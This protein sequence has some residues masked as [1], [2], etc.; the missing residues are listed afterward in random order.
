MLTTIKIL[1]GILSGRYALTGPYRIIIDICNKCGLGCIM[2]PFYSHLDPSDTR[3]Q[4]DKTWEEK[5]ISIDKFRSLLDD[6]IPIN[7]K[8]LWICGGGEPF[9]HPDVFSMINIVKSA[10]LDCAVFTNGI[11]LDRKKIRSLSEMKLDRM[12]L[13]MH[14]GDAATYHRIHPH[15]EEDYFS[16]I[17]DW[18][19]YLSFLKRKNTKALPKIWSRSVITRYN[20]DRVD[21]IIRFAIQQRVDF[22][23]FKIANLSRG[24]LE[25]ELSM[26][27]SQ[28][29]E[30]VAN[31][32]QY[33]R[34]LK[35]PNNIGSFSSTLIRMAN[36]NKDRKGLD[37]SQT[38]KKML[39]YRPWYNSTI[40]ADGDVLGCVYNQERLGN[41]N[42][43][44]FSKIWY[45]QEYF[46]FRKDLRCGPCSAAALVKPLNFI[47]KLWFRKEARTI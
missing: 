17:S 40:L 41:L 31:L 47:H 36:F 21:E 39:C 8:S 26:D 2:C 46:N 19:G 28:T 34:R 13:S 5:C 35:I 1:L 3:G 43:E 25:D 37:L 14:A 22:I 42:E 12:I 20:Y 27:E 16:K 32:K 45:S 7:V 23:E 30:L 4:R 44:S 18:L 10:G 24:P 11:H 38:K 29:R 33:K 15:A 6:A 9:L